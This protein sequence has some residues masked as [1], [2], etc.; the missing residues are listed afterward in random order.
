MCNAVIRDSLWCTVADDIAA[1]FCWFYQL[2]V[3]KAW[4]M[5]ALEDAR[6]SGTPTCVYTLQAH[7]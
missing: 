2:G 6:R 4:S 3:F 5:Q 7:P 1:L